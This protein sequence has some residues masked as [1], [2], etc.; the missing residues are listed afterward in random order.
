MKKRLQS[1]HNDSVKACTT[2]GGG[3]STRRA[4]GVDNN[5]VP[6]LVVNVDL[7]EMV[8]CARKDRQSFFLPHTLIN[9][10]F[11]TSSSQSV[12]VPH[13]QKPKRQSK[14]KMESNHHKMSHEDDC[15]YHNP[16]LP[17]LDHLLGRTFIRKIHPE[18]LIITRRD[19]SC[20]RIMVAL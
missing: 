7:M 15:I 12:R 5:I 19:P 10:H 2:T 17:E 18:S 4:R 11:D 1:M 3:V 13:H 20:W 14:Q 16:C 8:S 9:T 6:N